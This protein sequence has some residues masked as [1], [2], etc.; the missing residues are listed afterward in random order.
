MADLHVVN[1]GL[2]EYR[3][4]LELQHR[5]AEAR[6]ADLIPDTL[7][8]LEHPLCYT[9]GRRTGPGELPLPEAWYRERGID[10]ID[11]DRGGKVTHHAP[12]QLV[13]YPIMRVERARDHVARIERALVAALADEGVE[14]RGGMAE[15]VALTG[16]WVG[17]AKIASI[18]VH[19]SRGVTTHGFAI[20]LDNDLEPW[21]WIVPCGLP[22]SRT[23]SL[24]EVT[25]RTGLL[26]CFRKRIA[27]R[28][29]QECGLRQRIVSPARSLPA[30]AA[31]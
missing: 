14:A 21:S 9:R 16:V 5:Y 12:G 1:L 19:V 6:A 2:V 8:L 30:P 11:V 13:G 20:N 4:A 15:D 3:R 17:D 7:L 25:G 29:A 26:P 10:I 18:G 24:A 22:D 23:T 28:F 31:V 27:W